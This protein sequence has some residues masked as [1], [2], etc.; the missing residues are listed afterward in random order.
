MIKEYKDISCV[1]ISFIIKGDN[2][3]DGAIVAF[4][5]KLQANQEPGLF[6]SFH[7]MQRNRFQTL[8][9]TIRSQT[10]SI[11]LSSEEFDDFSLDAVAILHTLLSGYN[12]TIVFF[13]RERS[14]LFRSYWTEKAKR[15]KCPNTIDHF[16]ET[17]YQMNFKQM[18]GFEMIQTLRNFATYFG[19]ENIKLV[20]ISVS[21]LYFVFRQMQKKFSVVLISLFRFHSMGLSKGN[22]S[23]KKS[24]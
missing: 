8:S 18:A 5:I 3:K 21:D 9:H 22:S 10:S 20:L 1:H 13:H 6:P 15:Q 12:V 2:T 7:Y 16:F 14:N 17:Q 24:L 19:K 4:T 23:L 11:F